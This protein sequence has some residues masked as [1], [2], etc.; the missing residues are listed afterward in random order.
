M[1]R[2]ERVDHK[3]DFLAQLTELILNK[4]TETLKRCYL[5]VALEVYFGRLYRIQIE[6]E[7]NNY[8]LI[9]SCGTKNC[10]YIL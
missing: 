8:I 7:D 4:I 9:Q 2:P 3:F 6:F 10:I 1:L 5:Q